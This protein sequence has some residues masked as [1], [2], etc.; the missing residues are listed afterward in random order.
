MSGGCPRVRRAFPNKLQGTEGLGRAPVSG[1]WYGTSA[2]VAARS[3]L[4]EGEHCDFVA[5]SACGYHIWSSASHTVIT[6]CY[7]KSQ[8]SFRSPIF[9]CPRWNPVRMQSQECASSV[10]GSASHPCISAE[11][12]RDKQ[13]CSQSRPITNILQAHRCSP[14]KKTPILFLKTWKHKIPNC[15]FQRS[16]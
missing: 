8:G 5:I 1:Q 3:S 16:S 12:L 9:V 7:R 10:P 14:L 13:P 2:A 15:V 11:M 4:L 6:H